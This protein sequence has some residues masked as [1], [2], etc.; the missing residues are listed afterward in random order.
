VLLCIH[1][2]VYLPST[3][4][5]IG[6]IIIIVIVISSSSSSSSSSIRYSDYMAPYLYPY[7]GDI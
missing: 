3:Q 4:L 2:G 5:F 1:D 6:I 7:L